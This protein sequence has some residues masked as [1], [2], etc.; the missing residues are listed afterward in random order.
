MCS[1]AAS[2]SWV[3][4][5]EIFTDGLLEIGI[6]AFFREILNSVAET[7]VWLAEAKDTSPFL[8]GQLTLSIDIKPAIAILV[9]HAIDLPNGFIQ[10]CRH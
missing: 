8:D 7:W 4:F 5:G 2:R 6:Q 3:W 9:S 1:F 10:Q